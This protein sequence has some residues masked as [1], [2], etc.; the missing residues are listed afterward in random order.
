MADATVG[1]LCESGLPKEHA[2]LLWPSGSMEPVIPTLAICSLQFVSNILA[3]VLNPNL[4]LYCPDIDLCANE[5]YD[6]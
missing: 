1:Y 4:S 5:C 3:I 6:M 2:S